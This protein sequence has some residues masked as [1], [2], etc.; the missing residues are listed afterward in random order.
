MAALLLGA[1]TI[2]SINSGFD[3]YRLAIFDEA[4]LHQGVLAAAAGLMVPLLA[5]VGQCSRIGAPARDRRLAALRMA[6]ATD[7]EVRT[8]AS[9]ETGAATAIGAALGVAAFAIARV[10]VPNSPDITG[11]RLL[12]TDVTLSIWIYLGVVA[13]LAATAT[14]TA[15]WSLRAVRINPFG[16]TRGTRQTAPAAAP[17][18]LLVSGTVGLIFASSVFSWLQL[19]DQDELARIA[20]VAVL[21]AVTSVGLAFGSAALAQRVADRISTR[22]SFPA[23][24]IASRRISAAPFRASRPTAAVLIAVLLGAGIQQIRSAFMLGTDPADT[25]Y[26]DTFN[27]I[28]GVLAIAVALA[29]AGL[30]IATAEGL[31]ERRR[32]L[33]SLVAAGTPRRTLRRAAIAET[34][35]PLVPGTVIALL[36]GTLAARGFTGSRVTPYS[37]IVGTDSDSL[38]SVPVPW[39]QLGTLAFGAIAATVVVTALGLLFLRS[40]TDPTELRAAA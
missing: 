12:P 2:V 38:T 31:L 3:R 18:L 34:L 36:A 20:I 13:T 1:A 33:A 40:S 10:L 25:F 27:L 15:R 23:L 11:R 21:F 5:F 17:F 32:S 28:D 22:T 16:V 14:V 29:A 39:A 19:S 30:L 35:I 37:E 26:R 6:G 7:G 24:L 8:I 4:G 9:L